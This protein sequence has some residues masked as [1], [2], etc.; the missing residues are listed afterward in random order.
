MLATAL[1]PVAI[2]CGKVKTFTYDAAP[3]EFDAEPPPDAA[4]PSPCD[5]GQDPS[6][7]EGLECTKIA[8]CS[9]FTRCFIPFDLSDCQNLNFEFFGN[10]NEGFQRDLLAEAVED[11]VVTYH[12]ERVAECYE[13]ITTSDCTLFQETQDFR[14][15]CPIFSGTVADGDACIL[16]AECETPGAQCS[17]DAVCGV[18]EICCKNTCTAPA[19]VGNACDFD[20]NCIPGAHCVDD[21]CRTGEIGQ[22]C[23]SDDCDHGNWCN[24]GFCDAEVATGADCIHDDQCPG[25]EFCLGDDLLG[26]DLGLCGRAEQVGDQCDG[27]CLAHL[28]EQADDAELGTCIDL[29]GEGDD[30]SSVDCLPQFYCNAFDECALRGDV[31]EECDDEDGCRPGQFCTIEIT[32]EAEGVC[33]LRLPD[34]EECSEGEQCQGGLCYEDADLVRRCTPYPED[35]CYP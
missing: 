10:A 17:N 27:N 31:G 33:S 16:T 25:T 28:C 32:L 6:L 26:S 11:G 7:D 35:G 13:L 19:T 14:D 18:D 9:I 1:L 3:E 15:I 22:Q 8:A 4:P 29:G 30:C 12:P 21:V 24:N 34:G 2:G 23:D 20:V 5:P